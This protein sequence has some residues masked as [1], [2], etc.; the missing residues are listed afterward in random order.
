[1]RDSLIEHGG[2]GTEKRRYGFVLL[3][4][5]VFVM[6][7][8][9]T[10]MTP[11][12]ADDYDYA[13]SWAF[14]WSYFMRIDN[15]KLL[16]DS[17]ETHR[18]FTHGRVFAS[19]WATLFLMKGMP[20]WAFSVANAAVCTAFTGFSMAF[21]RRLGG[22]RPVVA[23]T[24]LWMLLW[25]C[26]PVFGQVFLWLDGACNYFWG[27]ALCW[28]VLEQAF[29]MEDSCTGMRNLRTCLLL[30]FAFVGGAWSEH[31]SFAML[32][33]LFLFLLYTRRREKRVPVR[34]L[35]VLAAGT[36]GYLYLM[37]QPSMLPGKLLGKA[38]DVFSAYGEKLKVLAPKL[39]LAVVAFAALCMAGV[40]AFRFFARKHGIRKTLTV[41]IGG[42]LILSGCCTLVLAGGE[43]LDGG[44]DALVSSSLV[45]I[46]LTGML[47]LYAL[48]RA[49]RQGLSREQMALPLILTA[50]GMSAMIPFLA[51]SYKPARG[52]C[53]P[54]VFTL[55]GSV[56]LL[57]LTEGSAAPEDKNRTKR[58]K[59]LPAALTVCY[60]ISFTVGFADLLRVYKA[61]EERNRAIEEALAGDGILITSPYPCRTKYSAQYGLQDLE[62]DSAWPT[63]KMKAFYGLREIVVEMP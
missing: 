58:M 63:D 56:L 29:R 18:L 41:S 38:D 25:I 44:L 51:A 52:F 53:A 60:L 20:E 1:M 36:A 13:F 46:L 24:A 26:M 43:L 62:P 61:S 54:V 42:I 40:W 33:I 2:A 30:P 7:L 14:H 32:V 50:G 57:C 21:F 4:L 47:F 17:M 39:L 49:L 16:W 28:A 27:A 9:M 8:I 19:G 37:F 12:V 45:G 11:L 15:L 35:C 31:I 55:L 59:L 5:C 48:W 23:A 34:S 3:S 6:V 10:E 22:E